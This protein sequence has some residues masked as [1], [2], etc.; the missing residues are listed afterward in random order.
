MGRCK[1]AWYEVV[2]AFI[3]CEEAYYNSPRYRPHDEVVVEDGV[4]KYY[5]C[6]HNIAVWD[7]QRRVVKIRDCGYPTPTTRK[8]LE[9]I[10]RALG[11]HVFIRMRTGARWTGSYYEYTIDPYLVLEVD[12]GRDIY[13]RIPH[14]DWLVITPNGI[15][16]KRVLPAVRL[17][18]TKG[19]MSVRRLYVFDLR[20]EKAVFIREG[21]DW[22]LYRPEDKTLWRTFDISTDGYIGEFE[23]VDF[24]EVSDFVKEKLRP[25]IPEII[26]HLL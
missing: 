20:R 15:K 19:D 21:D 23:M 26:A 13:Y 14:Y 4:A 25:Y 10:L 3:K 9:A 2:D 18:Q 8:R 22:V 7:P 16:G 1:K 5:L 24:G 12:S 17:P 11:C 6:F